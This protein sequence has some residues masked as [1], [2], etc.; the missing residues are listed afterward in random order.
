[1]ERDESRAPGGEDGEDRIGAGLSSPGRLVLVPVVI[2]LLSLC[3]VYRWWDFQTYQRAM[4]EIREEMENGR[5]ALAV[6]A[7]NVVL[8]RRP[9]SDEATYLLGVCEMARGRT[10]AA[11]RAFARVL[12]DSRFAPQAI[13]GRLQLQMERGRH[14][15]AEEIVRDALNDPR[16]DRSGLPLLLGPIYSQQGRLEETLRLVE[17]SWEALDRAGEGSS[18]QAINLIRAHVAL[19]T[20]PVPIEVIRSALDQAARSA[21]DDDRVWLGKANLAIR[22]GSYDEASRWLDACLER[23]PQDAAVWRARL[24]WAVATNRVAAVREALEHLP[25]VEWT[26][27]RIQKLAA[28]FAA[29]RGDVGS[30]RRALEALLATDPAD[31]DALDRLIGLAQE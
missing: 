10:Q 23:R 19:R 16:V 1:M 6:K 30:E 8:A 14:A 3:G 25:A 20:D 4:T 21:P 18:E 24:D 27:A 2:A 15:A 11:D 28:W 7:L 26:P 29:R 17:G 12:P 9:D 31:P 13:L 5:N 22:V